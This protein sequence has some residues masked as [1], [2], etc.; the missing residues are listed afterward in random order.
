MT[1][2]L[3]YLLLLAAV[4]L[5]NS[6]EVVGTIFKAGMWWAFILVFLVIAVIV[7]IARKAKK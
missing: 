1:K 4:P 5:L 2:N 3:F 6:C 7:W